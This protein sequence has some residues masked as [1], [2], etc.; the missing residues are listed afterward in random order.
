MQMVISCLSIAVYWILPFAVFPKTAEMQSFG[1]TS[2]IFIRE[3][4]LVLCMNPCTTR[5][6]LRALLS[7]IC[8]TGIS[9]RRRM[10]SS[11]LL[12]TVFLPSILFLSIV[13]RESYRL[14]VSHDL[15]N[16]ELLSSLSL[17]LCLHSLN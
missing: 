6:I 1:V 12:L 11:H 16:C 4:T 10:L 5:D 8:L 14:E 7:S 13:N 3:R 2:N 15:V 9:E 17:S